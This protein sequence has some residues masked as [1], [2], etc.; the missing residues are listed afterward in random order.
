MV[1]SV[2]GGAGSLEEISS[3]GKTV[4]VSLYELN[5]DFQRDNGGKG[6]GK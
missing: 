2:K 3:D 1:T 5:R 4:F 6:V